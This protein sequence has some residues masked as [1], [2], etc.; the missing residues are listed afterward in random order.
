[1]SGFIY[2]YLYSIHHLFIPLLPN[3]P[4][5]FYRIEVLLVCVF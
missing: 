5:M 2:A 1:L 4:R 3:S